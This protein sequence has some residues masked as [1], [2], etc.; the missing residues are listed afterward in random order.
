MLCFVGAQK[1]KTLQEKVKNRL[2]TAFRPKTR[3]C[4]QRLFKVYVGFCLCVNV[5]LH[6]L[7]VASVLCFLEYL[8]DN[9][10]SVCMVVN[11]ISALKAMAIIYSIPHSV[12]E[13]PQIK[14]FVRALKINRPLTVSKKNVIDIPT[15]KRIIALCQGRLNAVTFKAIFLTGYFGFFRLSNLAP[16]SVGDFD[17]TKHF[18]GGD[19]FFEKNQVKLLL[20]WCKTL[21][22]NDHVKLI[23]LPRLNS[24]SI[25]PYQALSSRPWIS[26]ETFLPFTLSNVQVPPWHTRLMPLLGISRSMAPG[27]RTAS[28]GIFSLM[29]IRDLKLLMQ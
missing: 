13:H 2:S 25:C 7:S 5:A 23:T 9:R 10:V 29:L 11:Y 24:L 18:T 15:L 1:C 4:Y 17:P 21:Q 28:G 16:H 27:R 22:M 8:V 20:K 26:R 14:Y 3:M 12:F 6:D 19:V